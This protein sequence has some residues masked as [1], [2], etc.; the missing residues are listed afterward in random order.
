M[1]KVFPSNLTRAQYEFLSDLIPD[2]KPGGRKREVDMWEVLNASRYKSA[3]PPKALAHFAQM[4]DPRM[5]MNVGL[6][7]IMPQKILQYCVR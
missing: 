1:S 5:R 4:S 7:K 6:E 3:K 2:P